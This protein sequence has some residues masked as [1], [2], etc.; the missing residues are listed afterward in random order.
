MEMPLPAYSD[1]ET[2]F[3]AIVA[4]YLKTFSVA[5]PSRP[6]ASDKMGLLRW[7]SSL[8]IAIEG[9]RPLQA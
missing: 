4:L 8:W 5:P 1:N 7:Y 2:D 3:K 9:K 6:D